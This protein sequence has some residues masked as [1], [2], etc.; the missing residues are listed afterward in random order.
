M[1]QKRDAAKIACDKIVYAWMLTQAGAWVRVTE[2]AKG[3]GLSIRAVVMSLRR[4]YETKVYRI[5]RDARIKVRNGK[6]LPIYRLPIYGAMRF[7]LW[8]EPPAPDFPA[9]QILRITVHKVREA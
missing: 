6:E 2:A 1:T 7:P 4:L 5:E 3:T 9:S 8:L